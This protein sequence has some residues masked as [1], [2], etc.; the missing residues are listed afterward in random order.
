MR[1][2]VWVTDI[3]LNMAPP[4]EQLASRWAA[5]GGRTGLV[6]SGDIAEAPTLISDLDALV[7]GYGGPVYF[8]LGNHD[9]WRSSRREVRSSLRAAAKQ[10]ETT[11]PPQ[12]RWFWL[13]DKV[14]HLGEGTWIT[15]ND[16]WY[17]ARAGNLAT[18]MMLN[19]WVYIEEF[20][21][22]L[23]SPPAHQL[24]RSGEPHPVIDAIQQFARRWADEAASAARR[25]LDLAISR[26]AKRVIFVTHIPPF[27]QT[28]LHEGKVDPNGLPY[29]CNVVMG[30]M[31]LEVASLHPGVDFHV[32]AGHT[33]ERTHKLLLDNLLVQVGHSDYSHPAVAGLVPL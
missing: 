14:V 9:L 24:A 33:H 2:L 21:E 26:G 25:N 29:Y 27:E 22:I 13:T 17:D 19:D 7:R 32:L 12:G 18:K 4:A 1:S 16:G 23:S 28:S 5:E 8:V 11:R 6:I 15:G 20:R 30:G 3:H 31:L 10:R